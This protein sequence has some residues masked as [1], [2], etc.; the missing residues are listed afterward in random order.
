M[1]KATHVVPGKTAN[2]AK[3]VLVPVAAI[4]DVTSNQVTAA[5]E[6]LLEIRPDPIEHLKL[7][8]LPVK[9]PLCRCGQSVVNGS[10][11]MRRDRRVIPL[12][13]QSIDVRKEG[14]LDLG[15]RPV[16]NI[17]GLPVAA[18]DEPDAGA[19]LEKSIEI[20][21]VVAEIGLHDDANPLGSVPIAH[22]LEQ[23]DR[24]VRVARLLH[25]D[26]DEAADVP[27][28]VQ[29]ASELGPAQVLIDVQ[30]DLGELD[31]NVGLQPRLVGGAQGLDGTVSGRDGLGF[32]T[33][34]C[35]DVIQGAL[36][37]SAVEGTERGHAAVDIFTGHEPPCQVPDQRCADRNLPHQ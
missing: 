5:D 23:P 31:G 36:Y 26:P 4:G 19:S 12:L 37:A 14:G 32:M 25:I 21:S 22:L 34:V 20:V 3:K 24:P 30:T 27:R 15:G 6:T 9:P 29:D 10:N 1:A 7:V 13:N 11:V 28:D 16:D 35:P 18:L 33:D 17:V 8:R 2:T